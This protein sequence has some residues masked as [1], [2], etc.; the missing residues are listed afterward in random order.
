[1]KQNELQIIQINVKSDRLRIIER[2]TKAEVMRIIQENGGFFK[3]FG[4]YQKIISQNLEKIE[5][6]VE[7]TLAQYDIAILTQSETE[8]F[9]PKNNEET[10]ESL[11]KPEIFKLSSK[12]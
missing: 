11:L 8:H 6:T 9:F 3:N 4:S 2:I 7:K 12:V 1:M 5:K 10:V